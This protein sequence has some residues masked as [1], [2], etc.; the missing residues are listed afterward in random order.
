MPPVLALGAVGLIGYGA[1]RLFANLSAEHERQLAFRAANGWS[2]EEVAVELLRG[3]DQDGDGRIA[4]DV[5]RGAGLVGESQRSRVTR[6]W[7]EPLRI[8]GVPTGARTVRE[9]VTSWT[10]E[11]TLRK[12]DADH[13]GITT[14]AELASMLRSYDSDSD[15][16]LTSGERAAATAALGAVLLGRSKQTVGIVNDPRRSRTGTPV[17]P[18]T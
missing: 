12:A 8:L 17:S 4:Y 16:R 5:A 10:I 6:R 15:G 14:R 7:S 3:F 1:Y 2:V 11:P 9:E 18:R 13:D